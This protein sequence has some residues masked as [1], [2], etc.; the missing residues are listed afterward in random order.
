MLILWIALIVVV[1]AL[2]FYF[3]P[4][5]QRSL[6]TVVF[7]GAV[8]GGLIG[9]GIL[10]ARSIPVTRKENVEKV[11]VLKYKKPPQII[12]KDKIVY[13]VPGQEYAAINPDDVCKGKMPAEILS[14]DINTKDSADTTWLILRP[15]GRLIKVTCSISGNLD[16]FWKVGDVVQFKG[17]NAQ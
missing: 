7:T 13:K 9:A 3:W 16:Q 17:G 5:D 11:V 6:K 14:I 4:K 2:S 10:I 1:L 12:Y 8:L 15:V